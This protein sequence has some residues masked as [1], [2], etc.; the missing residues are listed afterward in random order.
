MRLFFKGIFYLFG[1]FLHELAHYCAAALLGK[2]EGFSIMPRIEDDSFIF[3]SVKS[4]VRYKIFSSFV[5]IAPLLWWAVLILA[6]IHFGLI[7]MSGRVPKV[8]FP[9]LFQKI[10]FFSFRDA[11][12]IWLSIQMIWAGMLSMRDIRNVLKGFFSFSGLLLAAGV[13]S[14]VYLSRIVF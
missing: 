12:F 5:A 8:H 4:K 9:M 11:L 14:L 10:R 2:A 7:G 6:F 13:A 3:G 1:T